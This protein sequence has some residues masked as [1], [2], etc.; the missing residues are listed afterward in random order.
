MVRVDWPLERFSIALMWNVKSKRTALSQKYYENSFVYSIIL[1][2]EDINYNKISEC[3]QLPTIQSA[4]LQTPLFI[5]LLR[6]LGKE[7]RLNT[8][9]RKIRPASKKL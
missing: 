9:N 2:L 1:S 4:D 6:P 3:A 5:A 7:G 8:P